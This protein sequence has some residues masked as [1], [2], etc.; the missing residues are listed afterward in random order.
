MSLRRR[1]VLVA[2][3]VACA[4]LLSGCVYLRLLQLKW[5]LADFDRHFA[6]ESGDGLAVT[7]RNPVLLDED[8]ERFFRWVPEERTRVGRAERWRF[9]WVKPES[10]A[11]GGRPPA[12]FVV[13]LMFVNRKLVKF[14]APETFFAATI[15]KSLALAALRSL[16]DAKVDRKARRAESVIEP[17]D[18]QMA[19]A[20]PFLSAAGLRE[21]LGAPTVRSHVDGFEEWRYEF[22]PASARQ[23]AGDSGVVEVRFTLDPATERVR[24]MQGRTVFGAVVFDTTNVGPRATGT[25][26][27]APAN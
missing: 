17:A 19:A 25:M 2:S 9:R 27:V 12:E 11:D 5:Q 24:R 16:G 8:V 1:L 20:D 13:E 22:A 10:R 3:V 23:R 18:L 15:P 4:L 6:V 7:F 14:S 21:A 26:Q